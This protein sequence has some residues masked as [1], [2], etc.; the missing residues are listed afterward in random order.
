MGLI[1]RVFVLVASVALIAPILA[2]SPTPA[3]AAVATPW[4]PFFATQTT[5]GDPSTL[6]PTGTTANRPFGVA[7]G[8]FDGDTKADVM[9]V[10]ADGRVA[11]MKGNGNGT[12]AAPVLFPWKLESL[13]GWAATAAD[14][15]GD[16]KL[17]FVWGATVSG[18]DSSA[19]PVTRVFDGDVRALI[20]NGDGTFSTTGQYVRSGI[21]FH[22]GTLLAN[23]GFDAGNL[24]AGDVDGDGDVDIVT[25]A[26]SAAASPTQT[27]VKLLTNAAGVFSAST[28]IT[29]NTACSTTSSGTTCS[30]IY[31]PATLVGAS[32][33]WG[34]ALGDADADGDLDLF[35]GDRALY[36]YLFR[37]DGTGAF[38]LKGSNTAVASRPNVYLGHDS[39]RAAVGF[40]P[41]LA[42][43]DVN[44]DGKADLVLGIDS[45][46]NTPTTGCGS[47]T[48]PCAHDG[49][50]L[51]DLSQGAGHVGFGALADLGTAA[52]GVAQVDVNGDGYRDLVAGIYEGQV[53]LLRQLPPLDSDGD[54]ISDYVDNAPDASNAARL[55]MNTDASVT[56]RDQL[57]NDFDTVLGDPENPASWS[58]L[59]DV[60]DP[61]DDNDGVLDETDSCA[62]TPNPTQSDVDG[63][64]IGDACDPLDGRD[65][66]GD[67]VPTGFAPGDPLYAEAL[68]AK[69]LWSTGTTHF[70]IRIDALGRFFQN[71]F[72]QILADAATLSPSDWAT[73]CWEDYEPADFT[74]PY[75]PC[76]DDS[77]KTLTLAGGKDLP[78]SLVV[79][80]KQL[81][82][83]PPV[84]TWINDRNDSANLEISQHGTYHVNNV[85]V[86]DWKDD[87]NKNFFSCEPC[88]LS[89][90]ENY[91]LMK[92]GFDTLQ[93]TYTNKW[94]AESGATGASPKIDWSTSA[95]SLVSFAPGFNASDTMARKAIAQLGYQGFSA[96]Q[97]EEGESGNLGA[98]FSPE[99]SHHEQFDQFGMFHVSAD[100]EVDPPQ[101]A[102]ADGTFT[103][104]EQASFL[105]DLQAAT[106]DGGLTTW[107]IEEVEWSDRPCN[108]KGRLDTCNGGDNR[109]NNKVNQA[110][111]DA[112]LTLLDYV[113]SY[114][115]GVAM[116]MGD[117][118]LAK[119]FDNAPTVA[120]ADQADS[121]HDGVGDVVDGASLTTED[122]T[123]LRGVASDVTATLHDAGDQPLAGQVI[124]FAIDVDGDGNADL[125]S[126]TTDSAGVATASVTATGAL[127]SRPFTATW[128]SLRGQTPS[129][130]GTAAIEDTTSLTLDSTNATSGQVTDQVTV[131]ATLTDSGAT[132]LVSRT[133]TFT[134]GGASDSGTT[135]ATGHASVTLTLVG[136]PGTTTLDADFAADGSYRAATDSAAFD[137]NGEATQLTLDGTNASSGQVTDQVT[138]GATLTDDDATPLA[139]ETVTFSIGSASTSG[140]TDANGHASA[141]ITL[142][143]PSA[144][145]TLTAS[146]V[147]AGVYE[148]DTDQAAFSITKEDTVLTMPDAVQTAR[149]AAVARATLKE[150][151]GGALAGRTI[152]FEYQDKIRNGVV[153]RSLGTAVTSSTGVASFTVPK[154]LIS[155]AKRPIRATFDGDTSFLTSTVTASTYK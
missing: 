70:V 69:A 135:D 1:R 68:A 96:S 126:A 142:V 49:E 22:A 3:S 101:N 119:G 130:T 60:A 92:V 24:A 113:K 9:A 140:T 134:I 155:S 52:R 109:E 59:G 20:G 28:L 139:G 116:T 56:H 112:W 106:D 23:V 54:G 41:S 42:A 131:G 97:F 4:D 124:D 103:P 17:D 67:G 27:F 86:S 78:V 111:W 150:A 39:A 143:G 30:Q 7:A 114:P 115:G 104:Q 13:N 85:P 110:R 152:R 33:P 145:S 98:I 148:A 99:G 147:A 132:P 95:H 138:V 84:V 79:I 36:V 107:L 37:N 77:T 29:E 26:L 74:P 40:T 123:L 16:S 133:V 11:W 93:G 102:V 81:W 105:N 144:T 128:D 25:G 32:S 117:V 66:D 91:E 137:V 51:L 125:V 31:F 127:G 100:L 35:V 10:R 15:N 151:D 73:K 8:D 136:P 89:E 120:N 5:V 122:A 2:M 82:T 47:P 14:V 108:D 63:D 62:F 43:G 48:G 149:T 87:P 38:T 94:I 6:A 46:T 55:D 76:G 80:P 72:T 65:P 19:T 88:G 64:G 57:D 75:E 12:F 21:T 118:A 44:G 18:A 71:E 141:T 146:F 58:R 90:A 83:D 129:D 153:W 154:N 45:G 34:L 50:V 61:D 121:D 53:K